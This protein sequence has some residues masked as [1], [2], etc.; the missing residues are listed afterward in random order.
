MSIARPTS[1]RG[2]PSA[3]AR[4]WPHYQ[5]DLIAGDDHSDAPRL[6]AYQAEALHPQHG[7]HCAPGSCSWKARLGHRGP[8]GQLRPITSGQLDEEGVATR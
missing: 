8:V 4:T 7:A 3:P 2:Q 6:P 1:R 5:L